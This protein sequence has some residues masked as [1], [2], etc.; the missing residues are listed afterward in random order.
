M[1]SLWAMTWIDTSRC[2]QFL[3]HFPDIH[4]TFAPSFETIFHWNLLKENCIWHGDGGSALSCMLTSFLIHSH[5]IHILSEKSLENEMHACGFGLIRHCH[6]SFVV[7][8]IESKRQNLLSEDELLV[9]LRRLTNNQWVPLEC[10]SIRYFIYKI[11]V[12]CRMFVYPKC[13]FLCNNFLQVFYMVLHP[14][15]HGMQCKYAEN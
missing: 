4:S 13:P 15:E 5:L 12:R 14:D 10:D 6:K 3:N 9:I 2:H 7:Y 1:A 11:V 8:F